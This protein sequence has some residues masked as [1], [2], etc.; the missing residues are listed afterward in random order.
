MIK[1]T[2]RAVYDA[3]LNSGKLA[4]KHRQVL[5]A[6]AFLPSPCTRREIARWMGDQASTVSGA[7]NHLVNSQRIKVVGLKT[8]DVTDREVEALEFHHE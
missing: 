6:V 5:L 4:A 2:S 8:C 1:P 7:V 3:L